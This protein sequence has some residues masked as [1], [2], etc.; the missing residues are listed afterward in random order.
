[1]FDST[2][3][4]E[5]AAQIDT[6]FSTETEM[7]MRAMFFGKADEPMLEAAIRLGKL[8]QTPEDAPVLGPLVIREIFYYLLKGSNGPALRQFVRSGSKMHKMSQA[9]YTLRTK[10]SEE[11]DVSYLAK[12][13]NMSLSSFFKVFKEATAMSPIQ[14]QK[15]LR[16]M[17]ARRLMIVESE[18]AESSAFK[19]GY[20]SAT[21]FRR[22]YSGMFGFAFK[23]ISETSIIHWN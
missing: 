12:A 14:Y 21:Q 10:L 6:D 8:F 2:V 17:D 16:L 18:T 3:L 19:V 9:I 5:I 20:N 22:E 11:A 23:H 7:S 1:M 15:R 13:A 4:N